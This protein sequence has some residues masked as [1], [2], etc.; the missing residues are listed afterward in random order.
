MDSDESREFKESVAEYLNINQGIVIADWD[1]I[2][3]ISEHSAGTHKVP[4]V[5]DIN[6][7]F[8]TLWKRDL[9]GCEKHIIDS[10]GKFLKLGGVPINDNTIVKKHTEKFADAENPRCEISLGVCLERIGE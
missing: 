3:I 7:Y 8:P 2:K 6:F 4:L 9:D 5:A 10:V 1:W